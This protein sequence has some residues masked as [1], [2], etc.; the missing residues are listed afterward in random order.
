MLIDEEIDRK[1]EEVVRLYEIKTDLPSRLRK[2]GEE[3]GELAEAVA[4]KDYA[5]IAE[6]GA[7]SIIVIWHLMRCAGFN[8][9]SSVLAKLDQKIREAREEVFQP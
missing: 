6:E 7:D 8:P 4:N 5:A 2:V 9:L 3:T 1:L